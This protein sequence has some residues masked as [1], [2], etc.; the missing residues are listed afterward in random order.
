MANDPRWSRS[1]FV[2]SKPGFRYYCGLPLRTENDI[3]IGAL[4]LLDDRPRD[5]TSPAR[6]KVLF[7]IAHNIMVHMKT[8]KEAHEKQRAIHMNMC[9][10]DF[11]SPDHRFR[12]RHVNHGQMTDST[13]I[14]KKASRNNSACHENTS[15]FMALT[16]NTGQNRTMQN[17]SGQSTASESH[18]KSPAKTEQHKAHDAQAQDI[19]SPNEQHQRSQSHSRVR[20]H[21]DDAEK[22]VSTPFEDPEECPGLATETEECN[23]A[24][25][26]QVP[27]TSHESSELS[28]DR[29]MPRDARSETSS[30]SPIRRKH[31]V[32]EVDHQ[33]AFDRA[34]YLLRQSLDLSQFGGGGVVLL[35]TNASATSTDTDNKRNE[36]GFDD[37]DAA[38]M[39]PSVGY[40]QSSGGR[41]STSNRTNSTHSA[42]LQESCVLAAASISETGGPPQNYGRAD[43]TWKVSLTPPELQ[44]MCKRYPRGKL[45]EV[46][47]HVGTS[48]FD[49]EGRAVSG[50]LSARLHELVLLRRQFPRAK[51][52]IFVPMFHANLNR[53]TSC[54][55]FTNSRYRV[56]SYEMD[57]LPMLSFTNAIK[58]EIVRLATVFADQ[59]KSNFIGSISHELRSPLHGIL[60]SLEF[61]QET[62]LDAFQ[63]TCTNTMDA[64][65][66]TLLDTVAMVLDY[67]KVNTAKAEP[68]TQSQP[69]S[70][71]S[72]D[73]LEKIP[74]ASK[75]R[76]EPLFAT[77]QDCDVAL[78]TEE[79]VDGLA[80]GHLA[81]VRT[82]FGFD[83]TI[84]QM[85][86]TL[87][88]VEGNPSLRRVLQAVRPEVELILDVQ[89]PAQW[90]FSTQP[91]AVRRIVMNLFGNSL[92]Y[93][94]HG[95]IM[96]SLRWVES[97]RESGPAALLSEN[98]PTMIKLT[99]SDT[100]Q[101]ISPAYLRTRIFT[102]FSQENS[103]AAGTGLGLSI[104]RSIVNSLQ[105]EIDI[106]SIVNVGTIVVVT[107]P[108]KKARP[109]P[110]VT[111]YEFPNDKL[112]GASERMLVSARRRLSD[113]CIAALQSLRTPPQVAIYEPA[114]EYDSFG[115]TQGAAHVHSVLVQYLTGWFGFP[116][117]TWDFDLPTKLLIVDEI[118]LPTL[119]ARQPD[120]LDAV[121]SQS[122]IILCANPA[123][124]AI[125]SKDIQSVRVGLLCKPFGPLKL[126]RVVSR[127]LEN[128]TRSPHPDDGQMQFPLQRDVDVISTPMSEC[129]SHSSRPGNFRGPISG[130][131][132]H[133]RRRSRLNT[134][135]YDLHGQ[136]SS[137]RVTSLTPL[138]T[139]LRQGRTRQ[140]GEFPFPVDSGPHRLSGMLSPNRDTDPLGSR[141]SP[142]YAADALAR[143]GDQLSPKAQSATSKVE[144]SPTDPHAINSKESLWDI[145][146]GSKCRKPHLLLVDD[147]RLNLQL[148]HTYISRKGYDGSLARTAEDGQKAVEIYQEFLPDIIFM[149]LSMPVMGGLEA[150]RL[151]RQIEARRRQDAKRNTPTDEQGLG[152]YRS[153][154]IVAMTGNAKSSDQSEAFSSGVD[155][156]MTK[157]V[158]FKEVGKLLENW[159]DT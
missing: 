11:I 117:Q 79:V 138:E 134:Q 77:D 46:P 1:Q 136:D 129:S 37:L 140:E 74:T 64:C 119:L 66:H 80:T 4:F 69:S 84:N 107:L 152:P 50:R 97:S 103:K 147:N 53:W 12:S 70:P 89:P 32:T 5:T 123:R 6:L 127:A 132:T 92:K 124:H 31:L 24:E 48:L 13:S 36:S 67:S 62:E 153:A 116:L 54:F 34:A 21:S 47:E 135:A 29:T 10:A 91:G 109:A 155:L 96:V 25:A 61:L 121:S 8:V 15:D 146:P 118:H 81:K 85:N 3:N 106:K 95:Y 38:V 122:I 104:V 141:L 133:E 55:A 65:A 145:Q 87:S 90:A 108:M 115:Q 154:F 9:M 105:G 113:P 82:N 20:D 56:F 112:R 83:D 99:V 19:F 126:A 156:Y 59:Q 78:L 151:I 98:K 110:I 45:Y 131:G 58:A 16:S 120:Y 52:V 51:Q 75:I 148:L 101:G 72:N 35:D 39:S 18:L 157:P 125:L 44:R 68:S 2:S 76:K 73:Q 144:S 130:S 41:G 33:R 49:F 7:T 158:S 26:L 23:Q 17:R 143:D 114:M 94:K 128:A 86:A 111:Q 88:E 57:Y 102:P 60:A 63:I 149:D 28:R 150:T 42:A 22:P 159:R 142:A 40:G 71:G 139:S 93:T 137:H 14:R 27:P 43:P 100:G 30:T